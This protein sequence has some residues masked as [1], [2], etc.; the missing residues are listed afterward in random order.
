MVSDAGTIV[1]G[2]GKKASSSVNMGS[3]RKGGMASMVPIK[4]EE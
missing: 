2:H 3:V 1:G 4:S